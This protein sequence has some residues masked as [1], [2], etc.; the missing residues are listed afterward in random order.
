MRR[1][2]TSGDDQMLLIPWQNWEHYLL[3]GSR[4]LFG[5]SCQ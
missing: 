4:M 5:R 3:N 2:F 1:A